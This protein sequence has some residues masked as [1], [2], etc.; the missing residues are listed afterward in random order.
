MASIFRQ[1]YTVK[2]ESGKTIRKQSQYWYVDYK[3]A[4]GTRKRIK[5]F[6]D[7][8]ATTQLAA[9]LEKESEL[10]QAGI[11]DK[12]KEHRKKPLIEHL[13]D[14]RRSLG[15]TTKHAEYTEQTLR[16]IFGIC[17]FITWSDISGSTFLSCLIGLKK[18]NSISERTYNFY[19]KAGRQFCKWMVQDRRAGE[20][21]LE[22]LRCE[23]I[24]NRK[25]IRR[26]LEPDEIRRLLET[27]KAEPERFGLTGYQ[28]A[29]LY[30]L[31][32]ETGL[33]A[34]ELRSLTVSSFDLVGCTI[35]IEAA[36]AKNKQTAILPLRADTAEILK[37]FIKDKLPF[38]KV[39][40]VPE[41]TAKMLKADLEAVGIAY[42]DEAGRYVDFHSLRHTAGS[43]LAASGVHPKVAQSLMRHSDINLTMSLYTHTLRGQE[44]EAVEKL[45]DLSSPNRE[46]QKATGTDNLAIGG[47]YKPAYKKLTK[48]AYFSSNCSAA[49]VASENHQDRIGR[50]DNDVDKSLLYEQL[51]PA[52]EKMSPSGKSQNANGRYRNRTCDPL[53]KSQLLYQLS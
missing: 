27:T 38:V 8:T 28:R 5:G 7:K 4:D 50:G 9:K 52:R 34:N 3:T 6:K 1:R 17:K 11:I 42:Q 13:V 20:S 41:K 33:R 40:N 29:M 23:T 21:P 35:K 12:Y 43:L 44:S 16:R 53:I 37:D 32:V 30:R 46:V 36:Y 10:A 24:T 39:F 31:A 15:D 49:N 19:L 2:D 45:P 51:D 18:N 26:A 25:R 22:Y 14:F 47:A 48:K